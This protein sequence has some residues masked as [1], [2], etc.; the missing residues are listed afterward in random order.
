M[1]KPK[2]AID[3]DAC[4]QEEIKTRAGTVAVATEEHEGTALNLIA[5]QWATELRSMAENMRRRL[6]A[7]A[8]ADYEQE[9]YFAVI[10]EVVFKGGAGDVDGGAATPV[11][12]PKYAVDNDTDDLEQQQ[13]RMEIVRK[14]L[15]EQEAEALAAIKV[16]WEEELGTMSAS[17]VR[18]L[19]ESAA[20]DFERE[21]YYATLA[22]VVG[23][24]AE[25]DR[26]QR[27]DDGSREGPT[28]RMDPLKCC[29]MQATLGSV[30]S[31]GSVQIGAA[32][33]EGCP[34]VGNPPADAGMQGVDQDKDGGGA[35]APPTLLPQTQ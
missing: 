4:D 14:A 10:K 27:A 5:E 7:S 9:A 15:P 33:S 16:K 26:R 13:A 24:K 1:F 34:D 31:P 22:D 35:N 25:Q 32:S 19:H 2:Y 3:H 23:K 12:T 20:D 17:M 28:S 30:S 21:C 18:R 11:F 8:F 6:P 29:C